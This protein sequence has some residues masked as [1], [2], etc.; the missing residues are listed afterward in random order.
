MIG[1]LRGLVLVSAIA[2]ALAIIVGIDVARAPTAPAR[3]EIDRAVLPG[4]D[5]AQLTELMWQHPGSPDIHAI[6]AQDH[7]QLRAPFVGPA[8]PGAISDVLAALRGA[9][10]HRRGEPASARVVTTLIA[11]AGGVRHTVGI[12]AATG[13]QAWIIVDGAHALLVDDWVRRALDRD[14]L[15]LRVRAPLAEAGQ[16]A[17]ITVEGIAGSGAIAVRLEGMP[18]QLVRPSPVPLLVNASLVR[19][20]ERALAQLELARIAPTPAAKPR[21]AISIAAPG[22][23][24][25]TVE[26]GGDCPG[27]PSLVAISGDACVE[28]AAVAAV[29]RAAATLARP[30]EQIAEPRPIPFEPHH[31]TLR[32]GAVLD[33]QTAQIADRPADLVRV[34]ELLAALASPGE[35]IARPRLIPPAQRGRFGRRISASPPVSRLAPAPSGTLVPPIPPGMLGQLTITDRSGAAMVL[36]LFPDRVVARRGEPVALRL[37]RGAWGRLTGSPDA[38]RDLTPWREEP[39]TIA[40]LRI[41]L[42]GSAILYQR[43]AVIGAWTREPAS[44]AG[45]DGTSPEENAATVERLVGKLAAPRPFGWRA[46]RAGTPYRVTLTVVPPSGPTIDHVLEVGGPNGGS[47]PATIA[48]DTVTLPATLCADVAALAR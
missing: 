18:R 28:R 24:V 11:V 35:V 13:D 42:R 22:G 2:L 14:L 3:G 34:A 15:A 30:A 29:E 25:T 41:D 23:G 20:L 33:L 31:I 10:W 40:R 21:L 9:R 17:A 5:V 44:P 7:W 4:L 16:A 39:T 47:C 1:S 8:D 45:R 46:D 48:G 32:D 36:E 26:I 12:A 37:A 6:R 19:E 27:A 38:L 43:G